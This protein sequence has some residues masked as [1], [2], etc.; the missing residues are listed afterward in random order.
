[1]GHDRPD[2]SIRRGRPKA[3]EFGPKRE[4]ELPHM[5]DFTAF[6]IVYDDSI[7]LRTPYNAKFVEEIK[8]IPFQ[9]RSFVKDGRKL[10]RTL[11]EHLEKY[12]SYFS[13]ND[14]LATMVESL[15]DRISKSRGLSDAWT[16][17]LVAP[18]LFEFSMAVALQH[19]PDLELF[20]IR[21]LEPGS[22]D[23]A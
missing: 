17:K 21:I 16:V 3:P 19:F 13:S 14:E 23:P 9:V 22:E 10:E 18:E 8:Q 2:K 11:I 6:A 7:I 15:V 4:Y 20:D 5:I 1:M 12:E